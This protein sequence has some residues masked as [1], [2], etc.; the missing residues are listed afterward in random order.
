MFSTL[1]TGLSLSTPCIGGV[2]SHVGRSVVLLKLFHWRAV[3]LGN[4]T[5]LRVGETAHLRF[6]LRYGEQSEK[7]FFQI[8]NDGFR[9]STHLEFFEN[10][11]DVAVHGPDADAHRL[12]DFLV[13][14]SF[15]Q[16]R[17]HFAFAAGEFGDD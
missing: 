8:T 9:T 13:H 14:A 16:E 2:R 1:A 6:Q 12:R 10:S 4:D 17:Q 5:R 7:L 11:F 3:E 15:A